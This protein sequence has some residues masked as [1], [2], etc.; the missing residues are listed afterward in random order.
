MIQ[1][2]KAERGRV[3]VLF[4][5]KLNTVSK[6]TICTLHSSPVDVEFLKG[7]VDV[8]AQLDIPRSDPRGC[9]CG[10][11]V[12]CSDT[13]VSEPWSRLTL[14]AVSSVFSFG[15]FN[16]NIIGPTVRWAYGRP[17]P[18]LVERVCTSRLAADTLVTSQRSRGT[19]SRI[20]MSSVVTVR[21]K[22]FTW[23]QIETIVRKL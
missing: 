9:Q 16:A 11:P 10:S 22:I 18:Q 4:T 17:V 19:K 21:R 12:L 3:V 20:T 7:T 6:D 23:I 1:K 5:N 2:T 15:D 14:L 13:P 8:V